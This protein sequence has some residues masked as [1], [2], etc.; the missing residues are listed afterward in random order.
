ML[1]Y[2]IALVLGAVASTAFF[3]NFFWWAIFLALAGFSRLLRNPAQKSIRSRVIISFIYGLGF[4]LPMLHWSGIYVGPLPWIILATAQSIPF[5]LLALARPDSRFF[6]YYFASLYVFVEFLRM[7]WPFGGFG[8]GR[9]GFSQISSPLHYLFPLGGVALVSFLTVLL[10]FHIRINRRNT[11]NYFTFITIALLLLGSFIY[12]NI[13]DLDKNRTAPVSVVLI[14][15]GVQSL[16]LDFNATRAEV[17]NRHREST[18]NYAKNYA[19]PDLYIWPENA[20]DIDPFKNP[21]IKKA[22]EEL[23]GISKRE[24]IVGAVLTGAKGPENASIA[25]DNKGGLLS[26]YI[27][28]DLAPFG[29]YIPLRSIAAKISGLTDKVKDFQP[30]D[31]WVNHKVGE[32]NFIPVIC[33]EI[34][35]DENMRKRVSPESVLLMQTNNATFGKSGEGFQ[36]FQ[37]SR[38]RAL[39]FHKSAVVVSTVG[40]TAFVNE[41]GKIVSQAPRF[42]SAQLAGSVTGN[43]IETIY[44]RYGGTIT[45]ILFLPCLATL[46]LLFRDRYLRKFKGE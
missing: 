12:G 40:F 9:I 41:K 5:C 19:A 43:K 42:R 26:T 20:I 8:W 29:E 16:G 23:A 35:D 22:V 2:L 21:E 13:L 44:S 46:F 30:G 1:K 15:G 31:S 37:M 39:E 38:V 24:L 17:F 3:S 45:W 14:Q 18:E 28:R 11:I 27:K 4:F 34:L 10:A 33:F 7:K 32:V 36:Q 25:F 6:P